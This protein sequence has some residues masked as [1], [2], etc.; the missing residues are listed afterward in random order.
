MEEPT[1]QPYQAEVSQVLKLV[2]NSLYSH[3]EI[4]LRELVSNASDALDKLRFR[5][6]SEPELL[7]EGEQLRIRL[8]ADKAQGTLT[9][10][11]NGVGMSREELDTCLEVFERVGRELA[12]I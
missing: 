7:A 3:K 2:V 11:D 1:T 5:S 9:I 6:L 12:I 8:S 10:E 4:F